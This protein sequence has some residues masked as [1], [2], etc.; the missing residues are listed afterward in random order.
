MATIGER[1]RQSGLRFPPGQ[2]IALL[3]VLAGGAFLGWYGF[4]AA[5]GSG[6]TAAAP[7]ATI[8][9]E[10]Q[11]IAQTAQTSG[12]ITTPENTKLAFQNPGRLA[13]IN[14]KV[15]QSVRAGDVIATEDPTQLQ[16]QLNTAQSQEKSAQAKLDALT[17]GAT[18]DVIEAAKAQVAAAQAAAAQAQNQLQTANTSKVTAANGI[19]TAQNQV[20]TATNSVQTA[21]ATV[22]QAQSQVQTAQDNYQALLNGPTP[23]DLAVAQAAVDAAK[24]SLDTAQYNY[25]RLVNHTDMVTRPEYT[26]L[27]QAEAGYQQALAALANAQPQPPNPLDVANAQLAVNTAQQQLAIAQANLSN[28]QSDAATAATTGLPAPSS[29]CFSLSNGTE[30]CPTGGTI[31]SPSSSGASSASSASAATSQTNAQTQVNQ[32]SSAVIS[33][34]A[35]Y[36]Q[37][38]NNLQKLVTPYSTQDFGGLQAQVTSAKSALDTAQTNFNNYLNLADLPGRSETTALNQAQSGYN[39]AVANYNKTVAPPKDTDV[40]NAQAALQSAQANLQSAQ[41]AE[42]N[43]EVAVGTAGVGVSNAV[44]NAGNSDSA[45]ASAQ[46]GVASANETIVS[47]QK[48]LTQTTAP[49]LATDIVQATESVTQAHQAVLTAQNNLTFATLTAPFSGVVATVAGNPG[50]QVTSGTTIAQIVNTTNIELDAQV[51]ETTYGQIAAGMPVTVALD[52]LPNTRLTGFITT[53]VPSGATTQ[54]VVLYPV[55]ITLTVPPGQPLPPVGASAS[56]IQIIVQAKTNALGVPANY[57]YRDAGGNQVVDVVVDGKRVPTKVS[58][59]GGIA[60]AAVTEVTAGLKAGDKVTRPA[61]GKRT[62]SSTF[63]QGGV[64]GLGGGGNQVIVGPGGGP[65]R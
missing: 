26:A 12:T 32:A 24:V 21:Q 31:G 41:A 20:A 60:S 63:G 43:A 46:S 28:A 48:K 35:A 2:A 4:Q 47:A 27:V 8:T 57:I 3:V 18:P 16:I 39:T 34:Q 14:V 7:L 54:G 29:T 53:I 64:Q 56:S 9:V 61:A 40:Q 10:P 25:D 58:T 11:T 45:I 44:A 51:D 59:Q 33:A 50:D 17:A 65:G 13:T 30:A 36:Q 42:A 62:A 23:Q 37:A 6:S 38:L 22:Q 55:V 15:G 52:S 19:T 49:P 1:A 5:F